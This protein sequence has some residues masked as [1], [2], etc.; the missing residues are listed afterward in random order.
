MPKLPSTLLALALALA[1]SAP[2]SAQQI[3][4]SHGTRTLMRTDGFKT[5]QQYR[6][7]ARQAEDVLLEVLQDVDASDRARGTATSDAATIGAGVKSTNSE[8][9][10]A[11]AALDQRDQ[12]YR[13]DLA[14]FQQRQAQLGADVERQRQQAGVLQALPSA[15]RDHAEVVRLNDWA[16]QLGNT[17]TQLEAD[18]NGLLAD[19]DSIE[20][21]RAKLVQKRSDAEAKL[22][23]ARDTTLGNFSQAQQQRAAAYRNLR[24]VANYLRQV[25]EDEGALSKLPLPRSQPLETAEAKLRAYESAPP[26]H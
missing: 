18:R 12:K 11:K 22:K 7:A 17:R 13:A 24:T 9:T 10:A 19:H 1:F 26:A 23:G 25:R 14:Q 15:Q 21:D 8:L 6:S 3:A 4:T 16:T 5:E 20:A 2:L